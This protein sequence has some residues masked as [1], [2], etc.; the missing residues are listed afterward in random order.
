MTK[1]LI[2][3]DN[4]DMLE[5]LEH[6][7]TFYHFSVSK[8]ANG[9]EA[10][11]KVEEDSPDIIILD[12]LMPVMN[13]FETCKKL[14][15]NPRTRDIPVIFLSANYTEDA[16]RLQGFDLGADE[17]ML[18]PFNIKELISRVHTLLDKKKVIESIR[19]DNLERIR[20]QVL[21]PTTSEEVKKVRKE[22]VD[23]DLVDAL[24]GIYN[25]KCFQKRLREWV[26]VAVKEGRELSLALLDVDFFQ[27]VNEIY[28][29]HT[30]DYVLIKL[31]NVLLHNTRF[32][33]IVFRLED[34]TFAVI[35]P[36]L[37]ESTAF[38][39]AEKIR[40][41]VAATDFFD[42]DFFELKRLTGYRRQESRKLT[43]SIGV[44][45]YQELI[46]DQE[47]YQRSFLAL[48][49]AKSH[50]KNVTVKYSQ[51]KDD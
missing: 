42:Q 47:L 4:P 50:G 40:S 32:N 21:Y 22:K 33:D 19:G 6:L 39:E 30:G 35:M 3:D 10:L 45:E 9:K 26:E 34:N 25:R 11:E 38:Y 15:E 28:G 7:F 23:T 12:A 48:Q 51:L 36:D 31:A 43:V 5:T 37:T 29:E 18:K 24:S 1:V 49:E 46:T 27:K 20:G 16:H 14:K 44:A 8:A 13:G 2:V 41:A 17:Y